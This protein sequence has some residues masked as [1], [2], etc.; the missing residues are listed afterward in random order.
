MSTIKKILTN[1]CP[2][3]DHGHV[4]SNN[5]IYF[6]FTT[7]KMHKS[8]NHCGF[9]FEK[10]P[11]FFFGAMYVSY[12][13]NVIEILITVIIGSFFYNTI[14]HLNILI[15]LITVLALMSSFNLRVSRI[16]WIYLLKNS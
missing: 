1:K 13:L 10:E 9:K 3:C 5:N 14:F 7:N 15:A 12:A 8:C 4:Y 2:N 16:I 11:G 6:N